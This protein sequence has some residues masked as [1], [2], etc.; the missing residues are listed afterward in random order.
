MNKVF[1]RISALTLLSASAL[2]LVGCG[3][4]SKVA[5]MGI[6]QYFLLDTVM[7]E[8]SI[9]S[10][11][12]V[13]YTEEEYKDTYLVSY[14]IT[15][16]GFAGYMDFYYD[17]STTEFTIEGIMA[18]TQAE[19]DDSAY[20]SALPDWQAEYEEIAYAE[21]HIDEY[22]GYKI[23]KLSARELNSYIRSIS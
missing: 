1:S 10:A 17:D 9:T 21:Q 14:D 6:D 19:F 15:T 7:P 8:L 3:T 5:K 23:D 20:Q 18:T 4:G 2:A 11:Y 16:N 13:S 22:P 12:F